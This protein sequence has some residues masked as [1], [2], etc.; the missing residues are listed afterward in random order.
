[1]RFRKLRIAWSV[2]WGLA[3]LLLMVLWVRSYFFADTVYGE[4][5]P[6]LSFTLNSY[7]GQLSLEH[8][9]KNQPWG[10]ST[11][12]TGERQKR[13]KLL[14][15]FEAASHWP[16]SSKAVPNPAIIRLPH[17]LLAILAAGLVAVPWVTPHF[18]IRTLLIATMLVA[19]VLGL[20]VWATSK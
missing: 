12:S 9:P 18:S 5:P 20:A 19:V 8:R 1:M 7:D 11:Q 13:I 14:R 17:S 16:F 2:F 3:C 10:V 4:I 15:D 6:V